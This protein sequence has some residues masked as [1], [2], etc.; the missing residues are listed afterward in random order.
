MNPILQQ[1]QHHAAVLPLSSQA[2]LLN[3]AVYLEQKARE[4]MPVTSPQAR[5][6]RLT[7]A[8]AQAVALN[9]FAEIVDPVSWQ[10][11]QRQDPSLPGRNDAD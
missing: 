7:A 8:L 4:K 9:P 10:R 1:I 11:E 5:R 3:Y 6:D 2:E